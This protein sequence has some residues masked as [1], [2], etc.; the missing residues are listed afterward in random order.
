MT[1]ID[2]RISRRGLLKGGGATGLVIALQLSLATLV[3]EELDADWAQVRVEF[4]DAD[5]ARYQ[6][7]FYGFQITGGSTAIANS[8]N[9]MREAGAMAR[10]MLVAAAAKAWNVPV[11]AVQASRGVL[12]SGDRKATFGEMANAAAT[13]PP[14]DK[15]SL[16]AAEA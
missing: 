16:K 4:P 14:P 10:A 11:D 7:L 2:E 13:L 3:A 5:D 1:L 8:F 12:T 9:Q 6:N 15:V